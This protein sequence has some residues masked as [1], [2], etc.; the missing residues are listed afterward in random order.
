MIRL[1]IL[2]FKLKKGYKM[3]PSKAE[4]AKYFGYSPTAFQKWREIKDPIRKEKL[5]KRFEALKE[6]Y[7]NH[8]KGIK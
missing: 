2:L 5:D 7:I 8:S 6:Y 1:G 3:T 4:I